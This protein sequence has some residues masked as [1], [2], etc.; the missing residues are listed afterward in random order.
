M[1]RAGG[2]EPPRA[3]AQQILS[4][5][6]LPFH[7]ARIAPHNT[8]TGGGVNGEMP[9]RAR[10]MRTLAEKICRGP[11]SHALDLLQKYFSGG[12]AERTSCVT[13]AAAV[14]RLVLDPKNLGGFHC[15]PAQRERHAP[16]HSNGCFLHLSG[17]ESGRRYGQVISA[18]MI[19]L[20]ASMT[21]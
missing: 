6:C 10:P 18:S 20:T 9:C 21:T 16:P 15:L 12:R 7:H 11:S 1:V 5:V 13:R 3:Y 4:L 14:C 8:R 17:A 19:S 2:L